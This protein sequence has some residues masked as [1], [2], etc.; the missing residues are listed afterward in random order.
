M[1]GSRVSA[2]DCFSKLGRSMT[3]PFVRRNLYVETRGYGV[4][5]RS[6]STG[7]P[8]AQCRSLLGGEPMLCMTGLSAHH[9]PYF[10]LRNWH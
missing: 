3:P 8:L 6:N 7:Y 4:V 2:S 10:L 5:R 9:A 1:S